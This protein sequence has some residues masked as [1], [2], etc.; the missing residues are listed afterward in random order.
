MKASWGLHDPAPI[1]L[2]SVSKKE[3]HKIAMG[4][5]AGTVFTDRHCRTTQDLKMS[6]MHL[7]LAMSGCPGFY[8]SYRAFPPG[9]IYEYMSA[10]GPRSCNGMPMFLSSRFL[11]PK[12]AETVL[13]MCRKLERMGEKL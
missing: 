5:V 9:L 4:M 11:S 6:F 1:Y 13:A 7:T 10:A 2:R 12:D 3:L 8:E